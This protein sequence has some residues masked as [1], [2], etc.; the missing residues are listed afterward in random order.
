MWQLADICQ[1]AVTG[2]GLTIY[3]MRKKKRA[4]AWPLRVFKVCKLAV[5]KQI[6]LRL[7]LR[8]RWNAGL[9]APRC[10]R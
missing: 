7:H 5:P 8:C 2:C 4:K 1:V 9:T 10:S 6:I 3:R